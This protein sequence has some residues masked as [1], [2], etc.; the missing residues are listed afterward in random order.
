MIDQWQSAWAPMIEAVGSEFGAGD[1]EPGADAV[2]RGPIRAFLEP[3]EFD[4]PLHFDEDVARAHGYPGVIAPY[5]SVTTF[6][7][8]PLW[9]PGSR[10]VFTSD[11]RDAQPDVPAMRA[12]ETGLEPPTTAFFATEL[13]I[14]FFRPVTVGERLARVGHRLVS[15][16]P[17]ETSVG[18]GAFVTW[19]WDVCT[20]SGEVVARYQATTY[21]YNPHPAEPA[22]A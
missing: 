1:T 20:A 14:D 18:R 9:K 6:A 22:A 2:E 16:V 7:L 10:P 8:G 13:S 5:T 11:Q 4:C 17:K 12:R 19:E 3:L 21:S 15:C